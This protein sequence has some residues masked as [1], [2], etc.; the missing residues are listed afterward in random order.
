MVPVE[1]WNCFLDWKKRGDDP[2]EQ[3]YCD[4]AAAIQQVT[5]EIVL[6]LASEAKTPYRRRHLCL[7]GGVALNCV[8]N[9]NCTPQVFSG[10]FHSARG[11]DAGGALGAALCCALHLF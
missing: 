4:L 1:K 9:A 11:R 3:Q 10:T 7:A 2:L 6:K 5:E 8:A